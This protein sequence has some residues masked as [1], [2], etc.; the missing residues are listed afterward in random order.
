MPLPLSQSQDD[1]IRREKKWEERQILLADS[2]SRPQN[3]STSRGKYD[4]FTTISQDGIANRS[5]KLTSCRDAKGISK[6][7]L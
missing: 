1:G 2:W 5:R 4:V 3:L 6:L 7:E